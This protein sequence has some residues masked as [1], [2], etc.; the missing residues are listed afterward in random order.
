[1]QHQEGNNVNIIKD[2]RVTSVP[3]QRTQ[4]VKRK[5]ILENITEEENDREEE[6]ETDVEED[7][8]TKVDD[9][10]EEV[11]TSK[12]RPKRGEKITFKV[13]GEKLQGI[14]KGVG[15]KSGKDSNRCWVKFKG[16]EV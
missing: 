13:N 4:P 16:E 9:Q 3:I 10:E 12:P 11:T 2:G 5:R 7:E 6:A 1:M 15:K 8:T 14:I